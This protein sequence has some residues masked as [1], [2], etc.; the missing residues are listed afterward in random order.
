MAYQK[1]DHSL[2]IGGTVKTFEIARDENLKAMYRTERFIPEHRDPLELTQDDWHG[3]H[4]TFR[5]NGQP[6]YYDGQSIDTSQDGIIMPGPLY[7]STYK[8]TFCSM[9][10]Q[11]D[12]GVFTDQTA[13]M[14]AGV[15]DGLT[16]TPSTPANNDA[17]YF[18]MN[19]AANS[20]L[21][22]RI[23]TAK[24]GSWTG[25]WEYYNGSDWVTLTNLTDGT[26][27]FANTGEKLV[28]WSGVTLGSVT[29]NGTAGFW[30]RYRV[31]SYA[32]VTTAPSGTSAWYVD[33]T[34]K[35]FGAVPVTLCYFGTTGSTFLTTALTVWEFVYSTGYWYQRAT[36][37]TTA[38]TDM[39]EFNQVLYL[40]RG[41][42]VA[43]EYTTDGI[44]FTTTDLTNA[45]VNYFC[46]APNPE[47]TASILWCG[48]TPNI[49]YSTTD[50]RAAGAGGVALTSEGYIGDSSSAITNIFLL[51]DKLMIGKEDGLW[52]YDSAGGVSS[53]MPELRSNPSSNNFKYA[54]AWG[55]NVYASLRTSVVEL[56]PYG[57]ISNM[58][59][60]DNIENV[61]KKG[62]IRGI[63]VDRNFLYVTVDEGTDTHIYKGKKRDDRWD[64]C[65][66]I[67]VGT[68][69]STVSFL[70]PSSDERYSYL[71]FGV[72]N[73]CRNSII[74]D[75]LTPN[76]TLTELSI[77]PSSA[78]IRFPYIYG[79]DPNWDKLFQTAIV[80]AHNISTSNYLNVSYQK[81]EE[82]TMTTVSSNIVTPGITENI[83]SLNGDGATL[84]VGKRFQFQITFTIGTN[85]VYG[86]PYVDYVELR[87]LEMPEPVRIHDVTYALRD[88]PNGDNVKTLRDFLRTAETTTSLVKLADLRMQ[89]QRVT[90]TT[91]TDY[92]WVM[93]EPGYPQELEL[94]QESGM[95]PE[96][97]VRCRWK[98]VS[99]TVS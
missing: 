94:R 77:L 79:S 1:N 40:A 46:V 98:E 58:G 10:L 54:E 27:N 30:I 21:L 45:S 63:T 93:I 86:I 2:N 55:E 43:W 32:S 56:T 53:K 41:A 12:G 64:W 38:I 29:I 65:P 3:G 95:K 89:R 57:S 35:T 72:D 73:N 52:H 91:S 90:G 25:N 37:A 61:W 17:Y 84:L 33:A 50:G 39:V 71:F 19:A 99:F 78:W 88:I 87:G 4:G 5:W 26:N 74:W 14:K 13:N 68:G 70:T 48:E 34:D 60:L 9:V 75:N 44:T 76:G 67:Y 82:G 49:L 59:P 96:L 69:N 97:L 81:N 8:Y 28:S 42:A 15:D 20:S 24:N 62:T 22:I 18:K 23:T 85:L 66:F 83:I 92:V 47:A 36:F 7:W 16:F 51:S 11:D 31:S 6:V 80:E